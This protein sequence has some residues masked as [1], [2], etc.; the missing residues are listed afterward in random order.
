MLD[1]RECA[2]CL[3][4]IFFIQILKKICLVLCFIVEGTV[5]NVSHKAHE[6]SN[7]MGNH[8]MTRQRKIFIRP[9]H[10]LG[11]GGFG[12][13]SCNS[14]QSN[15]LQNILNFDYFFIFSFDDLRVGQFDPNGLGQNTLDLI[16]F[17]NSH[18]IYLFG[19]SSYCQ[20]E[21]YHLIFF[22]IV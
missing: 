14:S 15:K 13:N 22:F 9:E 7:N 1:I 3:P 8:G 19:L 17:S 5:F 6:R 21:F 12:P 11:S 10:G 4:P 16:F 2:V 18:L 20:V